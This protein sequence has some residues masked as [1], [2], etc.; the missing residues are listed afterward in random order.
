MPYSYFVVPENADSWI[1]KNAPPL[2]SLKS[3]SSASF[4][5]A[6]SACEIHGRRA[7]LQPVQAAHENKR[8][9][10]R[11]F[12]RENQ[13]FAKGGFSESMSKLHPSFFL[14]QLQILRGAIS[15]KQCFYEQCS[16]RLSSCRFVKLS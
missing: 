9:Y 15:S 6:V 8:H 4:A 2:V 1:C 7:S 11:N 13:V 12:R 10:P 5:L 14:T 16:F 3:A